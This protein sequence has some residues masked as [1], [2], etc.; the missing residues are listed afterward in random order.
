MHHLDRFINGITM[1]R[2]T[3]G[4]LQVLALIS[5]I[6]GAVGVLSYDAVSLLVSLFILVVACCTSNA[7]FVKLFKAAPSVE[8]SSITAFIL[9]FLLTPATSV[10]DAFLLIGAGAVAMASKYIFAIRGRHIFNPAAFG[11]FFSTFVFGNGAIWWTA[12]LPLLPFVLVLGLLLVRKIHRMR[13][14]VVGVMCAAI[15]IVL[16]NIAQGFITSSPADLFAFTKL[17][18]V[19]WPILFFASIMLTEPATTPPT[20]EKQTVYGVIAGVLFGL[21]LHAGT[22]SMSPELALLVANIYSYFFGAKDRVRLTLME[23]IAT[24]KD[25]YHF[26]FSSPR[27]LA[28]TAGQYLEWTLPHTK[29][30]SRGTRRYFTIA[31]APS[32]KL[33]GLGVKISKASSSFKKALL[34]LSPGDRITVSQLS[35]DF[36]LPSKNKGKL[37]FLA[38]G[39][40]ITPFRSMVA[41]LCEKN[42]RV[43]VVLLYA[44]TT[45]EDFAYT[46]LFTKAKN[47]GLKT[48]YIAKDAPQTWS[49]QTGH[50]TADMLK[51]QIPDYKE[52]QFYISGPGAMV[53]AYKSLLL[54]LGV[55]RKNITTD[56]FPGL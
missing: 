19:S 15:T 44:A 40:G 23:R 45:P 8:S 24:A 35:G 50:L 16:T 46:D 21:P 10:H 27:P 30:D 42:E 48:V 12:T 2:L 25:T 56:Y 5:I 13:L 18:F 6:F 17:V 39:I 43:D 47:I 20:A 4:G 38:G 31:S 32:E 22:L 49:G 11:A 29:P 3:L 36:T 37:A 28:F 54:S 34:A 53:D 26:A 33:L 7:L 1:Y 55:L 14:F 9:F 41:E 51:V 52:R